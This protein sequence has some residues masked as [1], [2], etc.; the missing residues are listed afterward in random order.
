MPNDLHQLQMQGNKAIDLWT[1]GSLYPMDPH[2]SAPPSF[3]NITSLLQFIGD[4]FNDL[5][6][7]CICLHSLFLDEAEKRIQ[8]ASLFQQLQCR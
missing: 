6:G 5:L 7:Y 4:G 8:I 1:D 2:S 3:H